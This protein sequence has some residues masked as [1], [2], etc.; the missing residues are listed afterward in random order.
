MKLRNYILIGIFIAFLLVLIFSFGD[1]GGPCYNSKLPNI[2]DVESEN[3]EYVENSKFKF[4]E[5]S[6]ILLDL[7]NFQKV[8][9]YNLNI[10]LN[11]DFNNYY[12]KGILEK[13][14]G[15]SKKEIEIQCENFIKGDI[16]E[17]MVNV[18]YEI[19]DYLISEEGRIRIS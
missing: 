19:N 10:E 14:E 6:I 12:C 16:L 3:I 4:H 5:N 15:N 11:G 17:G 7:K 8:E 13:L 2:I 18:N 9:I 1:C